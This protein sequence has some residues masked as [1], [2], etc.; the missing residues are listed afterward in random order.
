M[1]DVHTILYPFGRS[2]LATSTFPMMGLGTTL[3]EETAAGVSGP[4]G[5]PDKKESVRTHEESVHGSGVQQNTPLRVTAR[6][7]ERPISRLQVLAAI[8]NWTARH[9]F[10]AA[11]RA[12]LPAMMQC[13]KRAER[14]VTRRPGRRRRFPWYS[15]EKMQ[16][17][18]KA[19]RR[20][21]K[22][23]VAHFSAQQIS[24]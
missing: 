13:H 6:L 11:G 5:C 8:W 19:A 4:G 7:P 21:E 10:A 14:D 3:G 2:C 1:F 12:V 23:C 20:L 16:I 17:R 24:V 15:S 22:A 18:G 9:G